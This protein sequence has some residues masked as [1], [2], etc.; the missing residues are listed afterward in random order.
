ME[1]ALSKIFILST[2]QKHI[3]LKHYVTAQSQ[4]TSMHLLP[5]LIQFIG[6]LCIYEIMKRNFSH[7]AFDFRF[8]FSFFF[9][10]LD[11]MFKQQHA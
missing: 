3:K 10:S 5:V 6:Y 8:F 2:V 9:F 1:V 7:L 4:N 11:F